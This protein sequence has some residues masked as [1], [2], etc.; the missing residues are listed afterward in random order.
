MTE[1]PPI[2]LSADDHLI[3]PSDNSGEPGQPEENQDPNWVP[4]GSVQ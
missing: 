4:E 3:E 1:T 2:D